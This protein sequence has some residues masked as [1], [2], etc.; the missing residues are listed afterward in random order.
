MNKD[1]LVEKEIYLLEF[2]KIVYIGMIDVFFDY[3]YGELEYCLVCFE[4]E[5]VDLN[6]V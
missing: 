4:N 3:F 2:L 5:I 1:F 6:N